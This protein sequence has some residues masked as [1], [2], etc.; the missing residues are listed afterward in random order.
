MSSYLSSSASIGGK[1]LPFGLYLHLPFCVRKCP[2]CDFASE[3][4]DDAGGSPAARRYLDALALELDL[5]AATDEFRAASVPT[6]YLGGGTPTV[7]PPECL[8]E[9]M[10]RIEQRF[11]LSPEAEITVEANPGTV[12]QQKVADLLAAGVNRVSLGVQSFSDAVLRA[13]G[14]IHNA[15]E[16]EAAVQAARA[17]GC[18]DLNLDLIYGVPNQSLEEWRD[19]LQRALDLQPEHIATYALSVEPG[20]P[21]AADIETGRLP[22]PDDDLSADMYAAAGELLCG[23]GYSHY[24]ISNF[25][26]PSRESQHNRRYWPNAEYLGLGASAHSYRGGLRWNN[27]PSQGVYTVWLERGRVPVARA[28]ALSQR[29]LLGET[30]MLGLRRAEGVC[31]EEVANLCG[32]APR[33]AFSEEMDRL[34]SQGLLIA[35]AGDLRVPREKWFISNEVLAQFVA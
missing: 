30:L 35:A 3:P 10:A 2:Y 27:L 15:A 13:L 26:R 34:C 22:A 9:I 23:A 18:A 20:T 21:L 24:E 12:D 7:L 14:R 17:A 4:L 16:A 19:T 29:Q 1:A 25:A 5:R 6:V 33:E 32:I 31:E 28:E 11:A 8:A